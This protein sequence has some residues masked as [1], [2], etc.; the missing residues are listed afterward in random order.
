MLD[1]KFEG[2]RPLGGLGVDGMDLKQGGKAWTGFIWLIIG[3]SGR[4]L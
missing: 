2:K 4:L 3:N 1:G